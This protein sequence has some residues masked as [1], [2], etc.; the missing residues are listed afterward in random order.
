MNVAKTYFEMCKE[1]G[2]SEREATRQVCDV[3][4]LKFAAS[5][6][7]D[8]SNYGKTFRAIPP[9]VVKEMQKRTALYAATKAG[10]KTTGD[11]ALLFA[12]MLS[13]KVKITD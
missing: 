12:D 8:W 3:V 1:Q 4:G 7:N 6:A 13:P 9:A 10:I 11:K 5:Y 2:L